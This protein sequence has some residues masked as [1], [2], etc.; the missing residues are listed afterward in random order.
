MWWVA[1]L[2]GMGSASLVSPGPTFRSR[3][4]T[5]SCCPQTQHPHP[6][7]PQAPAALH[8]QPL[9]TPVPAHCMA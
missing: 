7:C 2:E 4:L 5:N 8:L 3:T 1:T 6:V 9:A